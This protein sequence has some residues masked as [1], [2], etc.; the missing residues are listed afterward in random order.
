MRTQWTTLSRL[1]AL[2]SGTMMMIVMAS[3]PLRLLFGSGIYDCVCLLCLVYAD[4]IYPACLSLHFHCFVEVSEKCKCCNIWLERDH[5]ARVRT[6]LSI[7]LAEEC[8]SEFL[9][10]KS[11]HL[12]FVLLIVC[13]RGPEMFKYLN[14][15]D[16]LS[17]TQ[18]VVAYL[19]VF[20]TLTFFLTIVFL[21]R[22][23]CFCYII[24]GWELNISSAVCLNT[25]DQSRYHLHHHH[26]HCRQFSSGP[27]QVITTLS[28]PP[29]S[30]PHTSCHSETREPGSS[31]CSKQR[32]G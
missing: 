10:N 29:Q 7:F 11:S 31:S 21:P 17:D 25:V 28:V 24:A 27:C 2:M 23:R 9:G 16:L 22:W 6:Y 14:Q 3:E 26:H 12:L 30:S 15:I 4:G 18:N 32:W 8:W 13:W 20:K 5:T 1:S 19:K